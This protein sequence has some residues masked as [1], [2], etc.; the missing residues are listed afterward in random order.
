MV[1][2]NHSAAQYIGDASISGAVI[3]SVS[4]MPLLGAH[5]FLSGT[6]IGTSTDPAGTFSLEQLPHGIHTLTVSIIGYG[7]YSEEIHLTSGEEKELRVRLKPV[8][9]D[10]GEL[11]VGNLDDRWERYLER[12]QRLFIGESKMADSV[13]ILNP[14]VLRFESR[15]WG[16]F[17]AEALAPLQIENRAT[18][19]RITYHLD[20]F[21]HSGA[22]TRWDGD[23][24]FTPLGTEDSLQVA[25]WE[26]QRERT[27]NGSLRHFL[28]SLKYDI[29]ESQQFSIYQEQRHSFGT[30]AANRR[31]APVRNI[32]RPA[33]EDGHINVRFFG[34]LEIVYS[35]E[36]EEDR[37]LQW[38]NKI[39]GPSSVQR[40]YLKLEQ[41]PITIDPNGEIVETYGA[42]RMG[43]LAFRRFAEALPK[44]YQP[45]EFKK[46]TENHDITS[47]E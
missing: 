19:Y 27:F 11:Y 40:S 2:V 32:V 38:A 9:Y 28:L 16:R 1:W 20:E 14:E 45:E 22:I 25:V 10:L 24:F 17:S 42:T 5:V 36:G 26:E 12:F 34:K 35:G 23:S 15:W 21:R 33:D 4:G 29:L 44:E 47:S 3:D 31:M 39:R 6:S 43:Y 18:G 37:Y 46:A 30:P 8:V 13:E 7:R 41:R